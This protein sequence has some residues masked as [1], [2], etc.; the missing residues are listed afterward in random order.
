MTDLRYL[1][2]HLTTRFEPTSATLDA[3]WQKGINQFKRLRYC[4]VTVEAKMNIILAETYAATLYGVEAAKVQP[5]KIAQLATAVIDVFKP[6]NNHHNADR[7][8]ATL[9]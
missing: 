9:C 1:G 2:A 7:F 5:Q 3:R 6:R 4:P 8:F